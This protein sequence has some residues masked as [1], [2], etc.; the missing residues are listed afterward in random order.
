MA[1]ILTSLSASFFLHIHSHQ[2]YLLVL[3]SLDM[4]EN[5]ETMQTCHDEAGLDECTSSSVLDKRV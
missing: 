2:L 3:M 5:H 4:D 1:T